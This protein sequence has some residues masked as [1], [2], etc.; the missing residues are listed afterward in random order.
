MNI[1]IDNAILVE[2]IGTVVGNALAFLVI[3]WLERIF[4]SKK[5][6]NKRT[7]QKSFRQYIDC[8]LLI[9]YVEDSDNDDPHRAA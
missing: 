9:Y 8:I 6:Q 3:Y 4:S 7:T 1:I 2:T 5:D